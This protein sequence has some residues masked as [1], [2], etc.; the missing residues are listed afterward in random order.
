MQVADT[1]QLVRH[2]RHGAEARGENQVMYFARAFMALINTADLGSQH[3][4]DL[5]PAGCGNF[6]IH[7][8]R[9]LRLQTIETRLGRLEFLLKLGE[10][11]GM[12]EVSCSDNGNPLELRPAIETLRDHVFADG[13]GIAGM[14]VEI[15]DE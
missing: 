2:V 5:G 1:R 15:G 14:D 13:T 7:R 9:Q 12:R 11:G 10:P 8:S 3:E 6:G 4:P